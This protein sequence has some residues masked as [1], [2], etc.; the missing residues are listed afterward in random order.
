MSCLTVLIFITRTTSPGETKLLASEIY[1]ILQNS[2]NA[3]AEQAEA[4][5]SCRR[6]AQFFLGSTNKR[7]K[8]VVLQ[9]D[10]L[11]DLVR[12]DFL[13]PGCLN[14]ASVTLS[15]V[16]FWVFFS[17]W[18]ADEICGSVVFI[19]A[20]SRCVVVCISLGGA[21]VRRLCWKS[22][23]SSASPSRWLLR[24]AWSGSAPTWRPR[25]GLCWLKIN[26][27]KNLF[28][29][30]CSHFY[31]NTNS[32]SFYPQAL[33]TAIASTKVM[34]AQQVVKGED[35]NEVSKHVTWKSRAR[36]TWPR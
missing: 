33:G 21:C 30:D 16:F 23:V 8:T 20:I 28:R 24:G 3:E 29:W 25:W 14:L 4:A 32:S 6:K 35:G 22:A 34:K 9:I 10:G 17:S 18:Y 26:Q 31:T 13:T 7:A 27:K 36:I 15:L 5:A 12:T 19:G 2:G 1:E 11:D